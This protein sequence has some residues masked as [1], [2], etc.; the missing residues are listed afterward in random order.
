MPRAKIAVELD[1]IAA[2]APPQPASRLVAVAGTATTVAA[3]HLG[4]ESYPE[5]EIHGLVLSADEVGTITRRLLGLGTAEIARLGA[6]QPGREDV[7]AAGALI[8]HE[9]MRRFGFEEV[10]VSESDS[11]DGSAKELLD[12]HTPSR[13]SQSAPSD[14]LA[15][16]AA[17][18]DRSSASDVPARSCARLGS[19]IRLG[20][21]VCICGGARG[22]RR[23]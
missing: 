20:S 22:G 1:G 16:R 8:L 10:T 11:L 3:I 14:F 13:E 19:R 5:G 21:R 2:E 9:T 15:D 23:T 4:A 12:D 18:T 6:V 17:T 7:I